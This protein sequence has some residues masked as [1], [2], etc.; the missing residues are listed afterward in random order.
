MQRDI[1]IVVV[2]DEILQGRRREANA[3][4]LAERLFSM[5]AR[6]SEV[7][8]VSDE[9]GAF[10]RAVRELRRPGRA[11]VSTGGLGPTRDDRTR[12]EAAEAFGTTLF[13][14]EEALAQ[15]AERYARIGRPLDEAALVQA[16]L[17]RGSRLVRNPAGSAPCFTVEEADGFRL[18]CL[19]G[20]PREVRA[21][22]DD[23][24]AAELAPWCDRPGIARLFTHGLGESEQESLMA[25]LD[26]GDAEFCSLPGPFGVEIQVLERGEREG[27]EDR[28][29]AKL[30]Q[31][32]SRL[33]N[34]VVRPPGSTL[35]Q[36]LMAGLRKRGWKVVFAESCTA[37]L[38]AAEFAGEPGVS[39]VLAGGVVC[40][41][42]E[43]KRSLLGVSGT[44]LAAHGAVSRETALEMARGASRIGGGGL[45]L[46]ATGI[47]GPDGGTPEKPVGLVWIAACSPA[48]EVAVE[49]RLTGSRDEIRQRAA[50]RLLGLG[51]TAVS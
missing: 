30:E 16:D 48:G 23:S 4:W 46:S 12:G 15:V 2:G 39:E 24:L 37:G 22:F 51:W 41:S 21:V 5:G 7:R 14:S 25:G 45:G 49:L 38:A 27:R 13:R 35:R 6:L 18:T 47:A 11:V 19:P 32:A 36:T 10:V 42:N 33:G 9:P 50:W 43:L 3:A 8:T 44:T 29:R 40:Y 28:A 1:A 20:V 17:P 31:V 34:A 26:L